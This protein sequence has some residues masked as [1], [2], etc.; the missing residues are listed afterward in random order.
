[1]REIQTKHKLSLAIVGV[2]LFGV[3]AFAEVQSNELPSNFRKIG[4]DQ[5]LGEALPLETPFVTSDGKR[6]VLGDLFDGERPVLLT[7][8]YSDCPMLCSLQLNNLV[9][10]LQ[11]VELEINKDFQVV[12]VS[13]DPKEGP[14]KN[15]VTKKKYVDVLRR[16]GSS[17]GWTFL[18]GKQKDIT[19]IAG[20]TG[21]NYEFVPETGQ[22]NHAAMLCFCTPQGKISSYL[23]LIDYPSDQVKMGLIDA[24]GGKIGSLVDS[25]LLY[26]SSYNPIEGSYT[27]SAWKIMRLCGAFTVFVLLAGLIP[28]WIRSHNDNDPASAEETKIDTTTQAAAG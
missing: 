15:K 10:A 13:I 7:L 25:F 17:E 2:L 28:Y 1:M 19:T 6:V 14:A 27:A 24:S 11:E 8:N 18:T 20:A 5:K 12:T 26:C 23:L 22:Y 16:E 9:S 4:V 3:T 21:F